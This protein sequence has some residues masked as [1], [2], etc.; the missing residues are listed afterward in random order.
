M[1]SEIVFENEA[2]PYRPLHV[3]VDV[4]GNLVMWAGTDRLS[5]TDVRLTRDDALALAALIHG[6]VRV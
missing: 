1:T 5:S 6:E 3:G 2:T 4:D